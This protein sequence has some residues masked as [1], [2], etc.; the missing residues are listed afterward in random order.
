MKKI[1]TVIVTLILLIL[2]TNSLLNAE[3]L[4]F[5]DIWDLG[6]YAPEVTFSSPSRLW[7]WSGETVLE[8]PD[9]G[10]Y[11]GTKALQFGPTSFFGGVWG[12]AFFSNPQTE[13]SVWVISGPGPDNLSPGIYIRAFN[14]SDVLVAEDRADSSLQFELLSV[15]GND[16]VKVEFFTPNI[17][18]EAWDNLSYGAT[19]PEPSSIVLLGA[20]LAGLFFARRR[21]RK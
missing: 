2:G 9:G 19:V 13:I 16:I 15:S 17:D 8:N 4:T 18:H 10:A 11:S 1:I 21:L 20:G 6:A 12:F 7:S 5:D 14:S 3:T